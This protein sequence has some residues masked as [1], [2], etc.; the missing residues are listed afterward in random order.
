MRTDKEVDFP[1]RGPAYSNGESISRRMYVVGHVLEA[2][3]RCAEFLRV[4]DNPENAFLS[5]LPGNGFYLEVQKPFGQQA[6]LYY[7][8]W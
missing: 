1:D 6:P 2:R 5:T 7:L 3:Y 8:L 4:Q